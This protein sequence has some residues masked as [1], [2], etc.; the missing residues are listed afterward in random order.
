MAGPRADGQSGFTLI[1]VLIALSLFFLVLG[2][3]FTVMGPSN[4]MY[5]AGQRKVDVQQSGRIAMDTLVR[6]IRM[7]GYFPEN[8]DTTQGAANDIPIDQRISIHTGTD[9]ALAIFGAATGCLDANADSVC[10]PDQNPAPSRVFLFCL[11]GTRLLSKQGSYTCSVERA[12]EGEVVADNITALTFAYYDV[13]N[14][15][16]A[17]P[18]DG[19]AVLGAPVGVTTDRLAVRTVVITLTAQEAVPG[20]VDQ[21]YTLT[22]NV[23]LRNLN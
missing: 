22:S 8:F 21:T 7:A 23:R 13:N 10:D 19:Q 3:M 11:S 4:V 18:L 1:E 9:A 12:D 16:L 6:Q 15:L 17:D 2:G 20:Q 14:N 5:V